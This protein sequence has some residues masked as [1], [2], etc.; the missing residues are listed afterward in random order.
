MDDEEVRTWLREQGLSGVASVRKFRASWHQRHTGR[1][2]QLVV[3]ILDLGPSQDG[4]RYD[5]RVRSE[6]GK[7]TARANPGPTV[8]AA[9]ESVHWHELDG[10]PS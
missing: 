8:E 5:V 6:D 7:V 9:L 1:D 4:G 2:V 3:E 10:E